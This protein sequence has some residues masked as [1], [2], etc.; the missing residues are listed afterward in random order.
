MVERTNESTGR[1]EKTDTKSEDLV[2]GLDRTR[3][4]DRGT[5]VYV[6]GMTAAQLREGLGLP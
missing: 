5:A 2:G 3:E 1:R 4:F 6:K